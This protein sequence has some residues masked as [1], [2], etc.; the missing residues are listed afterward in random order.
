MQLRYNFEVL[1]KGNFLWEG[2]DFFDLIEM[3]G[4]FFYVMNEIMIRE[5]INRFKFFLQKYFGENGF[6]IYVLKVFCIKVM[7]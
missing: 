5:N 6:I 3:Y 2:V 4:I 7:C 1:L